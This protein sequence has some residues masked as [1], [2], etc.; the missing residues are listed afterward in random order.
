MKKQCI[1]FCVL[2]FL[3]VGN[4]L[5]AQTAVS[6]DQAIKTGVMEIEDKLKRG[7]KVVVLNFRSMSRRFSNYVLDEIMTEMVQNG[8]GITFIKIPSTERFGSQDVIQV[9]FYDPNLLTPDQKK[10]IYMLNSVIDTG[11]YTVVTE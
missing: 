2:M 3:V 9:E 10:L 11:C 1:W 7:D 6:L 5:Y 8:S 4:S